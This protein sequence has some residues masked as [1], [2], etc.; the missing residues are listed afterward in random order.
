MHRELAVDLEVLVVGLTQVVGT[1]GDLREFG[2]VKEV[3]G[4]QV[5][6]A[7]GFLG[8]D[9]GCV[10]RRVIRPAARSS[11]TTSSPVKVSNDP[12]T[13]AMPRC[14]TEN[15][16]VEW[17]RSATHV[18][19]GIGLVRRDEREKRVGIAVLLESRGGQRP[20]LVASASKY[21]GT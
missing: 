10:D 8:V 19:A 13:V 15:P 3:G 17:A 4:A 5:L 20:Q 2:D 14:L 16:T 21:A 1:E 9:R 12:R 11:P 18:P 6:V 7:L